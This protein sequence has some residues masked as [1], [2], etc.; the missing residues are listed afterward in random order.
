[1]KTPFF[2]YLFASCLIIGGCTDGSPGGVDDAGID[3]D[4][5]ADGD[6]RTDGDGGETAD[7][8]NTERCGAY[9]PQFDFD[10]QDPFAA[11]RYQDPPGDL[12]PPFEACQT[13]LSELSSSRQ[14]C[15]QVADRRNLLVSQQLPDDPRWQGG[16]F[17]ASFDTIQGAIDAANHCDT[18]IVRP[19]TYREYLSIKDKDV[20]IFSDSW[21]EEGTSQDGNERVNDYLAERIDLLHFYETG[22]RIVTETR[23]PHLQPLRRAVRTILEGGGYPEGPDLGG[24]IEINHGDPNDPNLG[25]GNRRPMVNFTA[26]TT[27]NTIFD[28]FTVRLM[29]EQDHTV[30]G[31]GH[32]LQCRGGSPVI[33]HNLIY[34]NGS[35]G[36]GVHASWLNT[37]PVTPPCEHDPSLA[38]ET[39]KNADYRHT[40]V[41]YRPVP[42]IYDNISYQN[43]GLGFGNNHYSCAVMIGNEAFWNEV[44]EDRAGHQSPG[45]GIRHGAKAYL[46]Y[47]IAYRNAWVG[48]GVRQGFLQ[49]E[50]ECA[51]DPIT[52]NHIDERTQAVIKHNIVFDNGFGETDISNQ[53]G[54]AVDGA[55]LP[56]EPVIVQ[57]NVAYNSNV[58][59][60][61]VRNEFAGEQRGF[62][63]DDSYVIIADNVTFSNALAGI[64]C[65]GSDHGSS[66]CTI[67]GNDSYWNRKEGIASNQGAKGSVL[68]NVV[69]CNI[70]GGISTQAAGVEA[71]IPVL[72][73][74]AY[75]N[76]SAGIVEGGTSHDYNLLSGNNGQNAA[77]DGNEQ[78][79]MRT[80]Y[81][82]ATAGPND[83]FLD[84]LFTDAPGYD[85]RPL[86]ASPAIDSGTDISEHY[87]NWPTAGAGPDRGSHEQ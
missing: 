19:G 62:V 14:P 35:T 46:E 11:Q 64:V 66:Y 72:N 39:F 37:T 30:P 27:R 70:I 18:I 26:G 51:A 83:L 8:Q 69:A 9:F 71:N 67:V 81:A 32:T 59:G 49:P 15:S 7:G 76:V 63:L 55:G 42:L 23:R 3:G 40:N 54:I 31:H 48:I 52:C 47:N 4:A 13:A 78:S 45:L 58:S 50:Q 87:A 60:I 29:P 34:N 85:F 79:C 6:A 68:N 36:A 24:T 80:Q 33:R 41:Q 5:G 84:P 2:V 65:N 16:S 57:G 75:F 61:A 1:M 74:I 28:G 82:G 77:C 53:G 86:N 20:Q 43:N 10:S 44:P 21:D 56:E 12:V 73:N 25:C 38:Q 22:N 17:D